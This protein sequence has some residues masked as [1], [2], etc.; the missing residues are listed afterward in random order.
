M[1]KNKGFTLVELIG[2]VIVLGV[3]VIIGI[4]SLIKTMKVNQN[5]EYEVFEKNLFLA[6]ETYVSDHI[7]EIDELKVV[8]GTYYVFTSYLLEEKLIKQKNLYNPKT[9][10]NLTDNAAIKVT[11]S[12]DSSYEYEL[13]KYDPPVYAN[14]TIVYFNPVTNS[15]CTNYSNANSNDEVKTGCLRWYIFNDTKTANTLN[16]LLD[17]N[18]TSYYRPIDYISTACAKETVANKFKAALLRDAESW[19]EDVKSTVRMLTYNDVLIIVGHPEYN[20]VRSYYFDNFPYNSSAS[21]C[22]KNSTSGCKY[23]WLYDRTSGK[24]ATVSTIDCTDYGCNN[25]AEGIVNPS[26]KSIHEVDIKINSIT[27]QELNG[28]WIDY[29][30][31]HQ[32]NTTYTVYAY[33]VHYTGSISA[34]AVDTSY[35][36]YGLRPVISISKTDYTNSLPS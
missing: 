9:K 1:N 18:T 8:G 10:R 21:N 26:E 15:I 3:L 23:G 20:S 7:E 17:H 34:W 35:L 28:Y 24:H 4:P 22:T 25:M 31:C 32:N 19:N 6:A 14:G 2:I 30:Y 13:T 16:L 29:Y 27:G 33:I 36:R 5:R 12:E 11:V